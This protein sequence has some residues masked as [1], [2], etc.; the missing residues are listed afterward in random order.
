MVITGVSGSGKSSL[1]F[2][3]IFAEGQRRFL[4]SLS[5]YARQF[6][7][8]M[9]KPEFDSIEG[10]SPSISVDQKNF[11]RNPRSTVGTVTEIYDFLRLLFAKLAIPYCHTCDREITPQSHQKIV[12][13]IMQLGKTKVFFYSPIV[14]GRKGEYRKEIDDLIKEGYLR[15]RIDGVLYDLDDDIKLEKNKRHTIE[16]LID[17]V[18]LK[19]KESEKRVQ[20]AVELSLKKSGG[21]LICETSEGKTLNFSETFS[22]PACGTSYSEISP[23]LFSF[24]SPYGACPHCQGIGTISYFNPELIIDD[25]SKSIREGTIKPW[26]NA[27]HHQKT[28]EAI[29]QNRG[30]NVDTPFGNLPEKIKHILLYGTKEHKNNKSAPKQ[31]LNFEGIITLL[32]KWYDKTDSNEVRE[33]LKQYISTSPCPSCKGKRLRKESL[34]IRFKGK[35]I[36]DIASMSADRCLTFFNNLTLTSREAAIGNKILKEII[37]RL[38]FLKDVGL[39]YL[40]LDRP[41]PTLSGGEAQRIRLA[42]QIGSSLTGITYVLDEPS[43]GLH[44]RDNKKLIRT[45]KKIK[46]AGNTVIVVEHDEETI[47][48]SD[49]IIDMGPGA[50]ERGGEVICAGDIHTIINTE[51]SLTGKYLS[52]KCSIEVP[53]TRR[54]PSGFIELKGAKGNNLKNIDVKFPLGTFICVTGVSGSGKSTLIVDTFYKAIARKLHNYRGE[55]CD[56]TS[57]KGIEKIN[58]IVEIDQTPIGR[59]PRSNPATYTGIFTSIREI[60]SLLPRSQTRGYTPARFS[61]NMGEGSCPKCK[62]QGVE[63][64]EM[65]FLPDV[66]VTC[67]QCGGKRYNEET[68]DIT[69]KG[70]NIAEV[71][72]MTIEEA[73]SFFHNIPHIRNKLQLMSEVGLEYIRL[74]QPATTLSGGEA[75]RIKLVKEL[76]KKSTG[77][78]IYILDEPTIG[79]H[80]EDTK[81]LLMVINRLVD[82]GNTVIVIEHNTDVIKSADYLIDLGPEG[83]DKGGEIVATG[84]PEEVARIEKS[85]TGRYLKK[86]LERQKTYSGVLEQT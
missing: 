10:L 5:S 26:K 72:E 60:F 79:L 19:G 25:N 28:A 1:A 50:G 27:N 48:E 77:K 71:L 65:H 33:S 45:L 40:T 51:K 21:V 30:V 61:F 14:Q 76:S 18:S 20:E 63:K 7:E 57:I 16:V 2:D 4:E 24:N 31:S 75:Q 67:E 55:V 3:T 11:H 46:D 80:F 74:G 9:K 29:L 83:G 22:C 62:G 35:S 42:T 69:Y 70:K 68:L 41:T 73:L 86:I 64:I 56:Y 37:S 49:F 8:K 82:K 23:R 32:E 52:G 78:T 36:S 81:K 38:E 47:R 17:V 6:V 53:N 85:Y 58:K 66:F 34:A 15:V 44:P 54:K 43:I 12:E 84:T 13:R 39:G 59:T